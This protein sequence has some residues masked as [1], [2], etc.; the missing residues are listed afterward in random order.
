MRKGTRHKESSKE[1]AR[2]KMKAWWQ[3]PEGM[4]ERHIANTWRS[5]LRQV[6]EL[7]VHRGAGGGAVDLGG[8]GRHEP[9][10]VAAHVVPGGGGRAE[11]QEQG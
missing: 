5:L 2:A 10:V 3:S 9:Q 7:S 11:Q 8:P 6:A 1:L 4:A